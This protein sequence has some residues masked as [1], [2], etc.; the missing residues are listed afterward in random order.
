MDLRQG[1][2]LYTECL[3]FEAKSIL[4][5]VLTLKLYRVCLHYEG[6]S[7]REIRAIERFGLNKKPHKIWRQ[8]GYILEYFYRLPKKR[9]AV[10]SG[11]AEYG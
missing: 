7:A 4:I 6:Q 11:V 2:V 8:K 9:P 10:C 1:Y 5:A 3:D